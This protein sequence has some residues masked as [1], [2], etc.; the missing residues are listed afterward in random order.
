MLRHYRRYWAFAVFALLSAP[1]MAGLVAPADKTSP[2][3]ARVLAPLP[4]FPSTLAAWRGLP[5]E[6]DAYLRDHFGLR[7]A[8]LRIYA[9]IMNRALMNAGNP[10]V[11]IGADGWMFY[12]G[13]A[14]VQQ[15]AGL[16][17]RDA[18]VD[19]VADL[20]ATMRSTLAARG[21][22][23]LVA[24]PPNSTTIY[25][26]QMPLW[27]RN[28]G[29][30]TEYDV[31]L[32]DLAARGVLG[33][34]LRPVL[35][36]AEA[37]GRGYY[38]HDTHWAPRGALVAFNAIVLADGRPDWVLDPAQVLGPPGTI[39]GGD[40]ARMLGVETDV[41]ETVQPMALPAV[42]PE[43]LSAGSF[44][45]LVA[46]CDRPGPTVLIIGDSFTVTLFAPLL[47]Q[48]AHRAVWLHHQYC[49][50]DWKWIDELHPDEVWWMTTERFIACRTRDRPVGFPPQ[51]AAVP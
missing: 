5:R 18:L 36:T 41:S 44:G 2:T 43:Q 32:D 33:V 17:R 40:L 16:L 38:Q 4:N 48:H 6:L 35:I 25:G 15:S 46:T 19:G 23:F 26:S 12:R 37:Q 42:N 22:R 14:M 50:F 27:A 13:G 10:A 3:E 21:V 51:V 9:L 31:L 11:L 49:H 1:L 30:R 24:S 28:R 20:L 29:M 8:F 34:D 47:L 39:R 7:P 45:P